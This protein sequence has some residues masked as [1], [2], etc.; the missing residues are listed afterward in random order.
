MFSRLKIFFSNNPRIHDRTSPLNYDNWFHLDA[1]TLAEQG[2]AE[3]YD[4]IL[5]ELRKHVANPATIQEI[6]EPDIPLYA[7]SCNSEKYVIYPSHEPDTPEASWARATFF[8]FLCI[9]QQLTST[10]VLFYAINAD[11]DLGGMFLTA[12]E[13]EQAQA[14]ISSKKDW[15][16]IPTLESPWYGMH[17]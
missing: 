9:N 8:F 17:N 6:I 2:I 7:I 12:L 4:R 15:P 1:E 13:V 16:Y 14:L 10:D 5:P 11:N 3:A